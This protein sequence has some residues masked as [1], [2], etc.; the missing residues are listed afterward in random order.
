MKKNS[1][2]AAHN[3]PIICFF[4]EIFKKSALKTL[5]DHQGSRRTH[6]DPLRTTKDSKC[7]KKRKRTSKKQK[8]HRS[9]NSFNR[10]HRFWVFKCREAWW[11][12]PK[13]KHEQT[14]LAIFLICVESGFF[15]NNY[16][17][18]VRC[19]RHGGGYR[20]IYQGEPGVGNDSTQRE[21]ERES[22]RE[23]SRIDFE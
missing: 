13:N 21:R 1:R 15:F 19:L 5:K 3:S 14:F 6:T 23:R 12:I 4:K 16:F 9:N 10:Y 22:E 7:L 2:F 8:K 18:S 11:Q 17:K 20:S